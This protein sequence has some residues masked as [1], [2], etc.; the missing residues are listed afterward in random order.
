NEHGEFK[1]GSVTDGGETYAVL[2]YGRIVALTRQA[3]INDDLR[4]FDRMVAGF[5]AAAMRLENRT[6]Y[7]Q[8]TANAAMADAV[9]LFHATHANL[10]TG[11]GSVL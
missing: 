11:A 10:G 1:Y 4:A 8:L 3:I 6:V 2:T 7:S 9:A 5:G